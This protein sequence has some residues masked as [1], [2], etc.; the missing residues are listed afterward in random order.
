MKIIPAILVQ[1]EAEFLQQ[2]K[3]IEG[4]ADYI[5]IDITDGQFVSETTWSDPEVVRTNLKINCE[6]HLMVQNPLAIIKKWRDVPQIKRILFHVEATLDIEETIDAIH[7]QGWQAT[8]VLN[9]ETST[10]SIESVAQKLDGVLGMTIHP[11]AQGRAFMPEVLPKLMA[12]KQ[13]YPDLL[14]Q[15]DGG[16]NAQTLLQIKT[17]GIDCVCVGSAIFGHGDPAENLA[18]LKKLIA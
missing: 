7:A 4:A 8:V 13:K 10:E 12:L 5:H 9:P 18:N 2:T 16:V 1:S 14:T 6:L 11:G 17:A 15:V 3:A